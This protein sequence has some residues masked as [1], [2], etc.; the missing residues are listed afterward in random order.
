MVLVDS[1]NKRWYSTMIS[2]LLNFTLSLSLSPCSRKTFQ[3]IPLYCVVERK[4]IPLVSYYKMCNYVINIFTMSSGNVFHFPLRFYIYTCSVYT[5]P[6]SGEQMCV[7]VLKMQE[8]DTLGAIFYAWK[9]CRIFMRHEPVHCALFNNDGSFWN[10]AERNANLLN[11]F[12][13][14][15][16]P[17]VRR[18]PMNIAIGSNWIERACNA[19]RTEPW[20]D[21][22][23][24]SSVRPSIHRWT[25]NHSHRVAFSPVHTAVV[26]QYVHFLHIVYMEIHNRAH[27]SFASKTVGKKRYKWIV[28]PI[29]PFFSYSRSSFRM[30]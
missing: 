13:R 30:H 10:G 20:M 5:E 21:D 18:T 7:F 17:P 9:K 1:R 29:S 26:I 15:K 28:C 3:K 14:K 8:R 23:W 11:M 27:N 25:A 19:N 24:N 4:D 16:E 2:R 22:A 6:S 12:W